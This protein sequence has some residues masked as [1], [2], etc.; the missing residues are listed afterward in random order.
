MNHIKVLIDEETLESKIEELAKRISEDYKDKNPIIIC[1]LKGAV[2]FFTDLTKKLDIDCE[3]AFMRASSYEGETSTG[4]IVIKVDIDQDI[5]DRHIIIVEDIVDTGYT[6]SKLLDYLKE[7]K[8]KSIK[9][10]VLLDK[11]ERREVNDLKPDYVGFVIPNRFV[12]GYGLDYD[13]KYRTI[14]NISCITEDSDQVLEI[15]KE[16]IRKQLIKKKDTQ[17]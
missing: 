17:S 6:I 4:N 14:P 1:I 8:T 11:K 10:C 12:I 13:E 3:L 16:T 2:Y 9:L 7:K 15:D 5:K